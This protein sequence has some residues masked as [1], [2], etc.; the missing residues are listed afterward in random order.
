M[1]S[2]RPVLLAAHP[3]VGHTN[4]LRAIGAELRS[5]GYVTTFAITGVRVPLISWW[6]EQIRAAASLPAAIDRE[7][8]RLLSLTPSVGALWHAARLTRASGQGELEVA[9]ELFTSG[10]EKQATEIAAHARRIGAAVVVGDYLMPAALLGARLAKL[11]Y[12]AVYHSALPFPSDGAAPFGTA[13][14]ASARGSGEWQA[15]ERRLEQLSALFDARVA[16]AGKRLGLS[17]LPTGLL[18]RPISTDLNILATAPE[19]EPGLLPVEGPVLMTGPCLPAENS[20]KPDETE[21]LEC[22]P[23]GGFMTYVS[24]GTVFNDKPALFR[25]LIDGAT[26]TG[27]HVVVSAGASFPL[28]AKLQLPK[29]QVFRRVPQVALLQRVNTVITHGGNNTVQECLAAGRPMVVVPF[30]GDQVANAQRVERL[31][32]GVSLAAAHLT[33]EAIRRALSS[34]S[35]PAVLE[36]AGALS[37]ALTS[38]GGASAAAQSIVD[39]VASSQRQSK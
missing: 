8:S 7:G 5:R 1:N 12:V 35:A 17:L 20:L 22:L 32:V 25:A 13:L 3:T 38:Y 36:R 23:T 11:P 16:R 21:L 9:I 18:L 10:M 27:A 39:L 6:P 37:R 31:G 15:A 24:L 2:G 34:I 29:V 33:P 19:L 14:P 4:A 28:L 30:G 26:A